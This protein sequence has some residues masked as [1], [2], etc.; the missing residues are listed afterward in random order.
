MIDPPGPPRV[1]V[2][3]PAFNAEPFVAAAV[4][5]ILGQTLSDLELIVVDDGS[6]DGTPAILADR[7]A[8]DPRVR[9][10]G[11]GH[12]GVVP[13]LN[14]GLRE[15]RADYVAIM[16]ADDVSLPERLER[17]AAF[18]DAHP[19]VAAVGGQSC[20]MLADGTRG[21][22]TSLPL[23][24]AAL[25]AIM[26]QA[27]PLA[28][29]TVMLRR[30]AVLEIG[31]YR[32]QFASAAED[33]D[34]WLRL[35]ERLELANLSDV[36]LLYRLH[37]GQLTGQASEGVAI[38]TLVARAAAR[39]RRAGLPD[40]VAGLTTIDRELAEK[41][42]IPAAEIARLAIENALSRGECL[43]TVAAPAAA[44]RGPLEALRGHAAAAREPGLFVGADRWL[45]A[46]LLAREG[47][48]AR[49]L[50]LFAGAAAADGAFRRRLVG[51]VR[52]RV[53]GRWWPA[54]GLPAC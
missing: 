42:G 9:I 1:S 23:E 54:R 49:A 4:D 24:P 51:A 5:S 3:L 41:L 21:A 40:P 43:A 19:T 10:L 6:T 25:R 33:Y 7:A 44:C 48:W 46:R 35:S 28:N 17:Q 15:A 32:P 16:N 38:A 45:R 30:D 26:M 2:V 52:R 8:R 13:A 34:L 36:V 37:A 18:L 20:L 31:G 39:A 11:R 50:P 22:V 14:D 53:A 47:R 12:R 27:A 29:P